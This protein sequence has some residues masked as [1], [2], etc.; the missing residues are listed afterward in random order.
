MLSMIASS[1]DSPSVNGTNRKLYIAVRPN[2]RR[3]S[4]TIS[5]SVTTF[6]RVRGTYGNMT[7][8]R[9]PRALTIFAARQKPARLARIM[10]APTNAIGNSRHGL[11]GYARTPLSNVMQPAKHSVARIRAGEDRRPGRLRTDHN[12][13][14][15]I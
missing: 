1:T 14:A 7:P 2:C 3:D 13:P 15:P 12:L 11:T 10:L 9:G 5:M 4:S 6:E 8:D